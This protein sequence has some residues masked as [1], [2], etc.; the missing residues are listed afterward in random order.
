[1]QSKTVRIMLFGLLV[2]VH[3]RHSSCCSSNPCE[4]IACRSCEAR[5]DE[6]FDGESDEGERRQRAHLIPRKFNGL[7]VS[8]V[9]LI[10][11]ALRGPVVQEWA[12]IDPHA[13]R[14]QQ[15]RNGLRARVGLSVV[16]MIA[17]V[18]NPRTSM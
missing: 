1:M 6:R 12:E 3:C 9:V 16:R 10:V 17:R 5:V 15:S 7:P 4:R 11:D 13:A 8:V 14:P 18:L 2:Y